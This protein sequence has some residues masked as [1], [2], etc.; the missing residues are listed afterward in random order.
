VL[1]APGRAASVRITT[2]TATEP[3]SGDAGKVVQIAKGSSVVVPVA[4]AASTKASQFMVIVTPLPGSGP[5]YAGQLVSAGGSLRSVLPVPS[6]LTWI[7][8]PPVTD[9]LSQASG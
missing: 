2:A 5:V 7:P 8:L 3:A 4:P 6:S 1:S 9:A